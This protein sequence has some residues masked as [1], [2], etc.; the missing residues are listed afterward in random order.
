LH[1]IACLVLPFLF[2]A[3]GRE[4]GEHHVFHFIRRGGS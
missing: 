2:T 3:R 4:A 1:S